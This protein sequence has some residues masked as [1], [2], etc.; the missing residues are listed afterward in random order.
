MYKYRKPSKRES[1]ARFPRFS[2]MFHFFAIFPK[3]KAKTRKIWET[4]GKKRE[5]GSFW[6][7]YIFLFCHYFGLFF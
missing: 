2:Y 7:S 5:L 4:L 1:L 3:K 6:F